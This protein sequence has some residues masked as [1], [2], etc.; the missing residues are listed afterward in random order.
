M[1]LVSFGRLPSSSQAAWCTDIKATYPRRFSFDSSAAPIEWMTDNGNA[2][3]AGLPLLLKVVD[4]FG[5]DVIHSN[6]FCFGALPLEIPTIVTAHSDVLSW[7][8]ACR[9]EGLESSAWLD[10]YCAL[11]SKGLTG[12]AVV[13]APTRWMLD[14]LSKHHRLSSASR[15]ILNGRGP[16]SLPTK[17]RRMQ[18]VSAGRFWDEGKNLSLLA[19]MNAPLPIVVAGEEHYQ[20]STVQS[21]GDLQMTGSVSENDLLRLFNKSSIYIAPSRYEP[22]GLAPLEAALCGCALVMNDLPSFREIWGDH[23]LYFRDK[24]ELQFLLHLLYSSDADLLL[25][26]TMANRR[27][28]QLTAARMTDEYLSVYLDVLQSASVNK[29]ECAYHAS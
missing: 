1:A 2:Y 12:A 11:V 20:T 18:A 7:A 22:F 23:A 16:F 24:E 19:G 27:A 14:A 28:R 10:R 15:V 21:H 9:P 29:Q 4:R 26:R 5:P 6:Q 17:R 8:A 13:T 3:E 25:A